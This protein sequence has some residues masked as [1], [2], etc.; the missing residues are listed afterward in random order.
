M[1]GIALMP[2]QPKVPVLP[3]QVERVGLMATKVCFSWESVPL[4]SHKH[5]YQTCGLYIRSHKG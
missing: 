2:V 5:V 3:L 1:A 4:V